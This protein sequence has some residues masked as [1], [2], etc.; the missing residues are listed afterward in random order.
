LAEEAE[1]N[2]KVRRASQILLLQRHRAPGVK[3]WELKKALGRDYMKTIDILN[4]QLDRLDLIV[5]IVYEEGTQIQEPTSQQLDRAR[6]F[7]I[8]KK[9]PHK[10]DVI[11]AGWRIDDLSVLAASIAYIISRRGKAPRRDVEELLKDKFPKWRVDLNLDRFVR[12]GYLI[13]SEDI[14]SIGWRT[15]AEIDQRTL[16]N[17]ILATPGAGEKKGEV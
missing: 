11:S 17:L 6:F 8:M 1:V 16:L 10:S 2:R 9:P 5:K 15:R 7:I 13:E 14:L 3:G 4:S 12:R